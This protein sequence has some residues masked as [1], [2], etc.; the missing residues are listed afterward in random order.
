MS[1]GRIC[2]RVVATATPDESV[3]V[4]ARRMEENNVGTLVVVD[5]ARRPLGI[6]TDRD[7][8]TRTVAAERLPRE[9]PVKAV[10]TPE[11]RAVDEA[12]PIE[13]A[14]AS[15]AS[16]GVRRLVVTVESIGRLLRKE[17]PALQV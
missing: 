7:I 12:T 16:I 11:V 9:T 14:V 4:V 1:V 2:T 6:V 17:L 3:L 8:V 5:E 15:M 13:Q 10:M